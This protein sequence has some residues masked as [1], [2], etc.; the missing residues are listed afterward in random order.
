MVVDNGL[1]C[2][3]IAHDMEQNHME[4]YCRIFTLIFRA[5][6]MAKSRYHWGFGVAKA[7]DRKEWSRVAVR[8]RRSHP[9]DP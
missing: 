8:D 2:G 6:I 9:K 4:K 1:A 3:E 5:D 7:S